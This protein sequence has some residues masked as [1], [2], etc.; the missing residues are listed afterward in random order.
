MMSLL[1]PPPL[2]AISIA[3]SPSGM[4]SLYTQTPLTTASTAS[5]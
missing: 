4:A 5:S 3:H 1:L 2:K